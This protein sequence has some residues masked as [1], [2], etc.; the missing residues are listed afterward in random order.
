MPEARTDAGGAMENRRLLS[1]TDDESGKVRLLERRVVVGA[2]GFCFSSR[3]C[4]SVSIRRVQT[5]NVAGLLEPGLQSDVSERLTRRGSC[6]FRV[7][8]GPEPEEESRV[9]F[10]RSLP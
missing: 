7:N 3:R 10:Y 6:G 8:P 9:C 4:V 5:Q 2:P 1:Q